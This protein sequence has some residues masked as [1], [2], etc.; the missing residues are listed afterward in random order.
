MALLASDLPNEV[1]EKML[2][3][4]DIVGQ[5]S[6]ALPWMFPMHTVLEVMD[7]SLQLINVTDSCAILAG[8][9]HTVPL[10]RGKI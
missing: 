7:S 3:Y 9:F 8:D 4:S 1:R 6:T 5:T 2:L 10:L